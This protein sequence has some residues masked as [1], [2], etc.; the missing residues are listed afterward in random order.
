[1]K[2]IPPHRPANPAQLKR[3]IHIQ[4]TIEVLKSIGAPP[5]GSLVSGCRI[6][7]EALGLPED[8]VERIWK[9]CSWRKS[10][11]PVMQKHSKAIAERTGLDHTH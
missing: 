5:R 2:P 10:F 1:M 7:A 8:T 11:V 6:V 9:A 4:F 3:D